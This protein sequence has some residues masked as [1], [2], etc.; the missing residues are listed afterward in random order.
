MRYAPAEPVKARHLAPS[1]HPDSARHPVFCISAS[2][3]LKRNAVRP[4]LQSVRRIGMRIVRSTVFLLLIACQH[5]LP[6]LDVLAPL[7][8]ELDREVSDLDPQLQLLVFDDTVTAA[9]FKD[10]A[11]SRHFRIA[12]KAG[13][14]L[15]PSNP[16]Q[17]THGYLLHVRVD[18]MFGDSAVTRVSGICIGPF[19]PLL[20]G[21]QILVRRKDGKWEVGRVL[22]WSKSPLGLIAPRPLTNV[23]VDKHFFGCAVATMVVMC[24]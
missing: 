6:D 24:S 13:T 16:A 3:W 23:A 14:L 18:T 9:V 20:I 17:G 7:A 4:A 5:R 8:S 10:I 15:C 1:R 21:E 19:G 22:G 11:H 12:P 2:S